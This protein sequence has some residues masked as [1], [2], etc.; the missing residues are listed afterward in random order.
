[1]N[2]QR[3]FLKIKFIILM[4]YHTLICS[5][6]AIS[7][8]SVADLRGDSS[9]TPIGLYAPALSKDIGIQ[10][11]QV[12]FGEKLIINSED[13]SGDSVHV[14]ALEQEIRMDGQKWIGCP[15][16]VHKN[17]IVETEVFPEYN[18]VL[19]DLWTDVY[20]EKNENSGIVITLACGTMLE[21]KKINQEWWQVYFLGK[22]FGFL[23]NSNSIYELT[24]D[25]K[26]SE[27][28]IRTRIVEI[29]KNFVSCPYVWGGR[30]PL[31]KKLENEI[32]GQNQIT[33]IDCSDFTNVVFKAVGLQIPKNSISQFLGVFKVIEHGKDLKPGDLL[34]FRRINDSKI[35]HVMLYIGNDETIESTGLGVSSVQEAID[36][37]ID[38]KNLG[39]RIIKLHDYIGVSHDQIES[40]KT[41][42]EKRGY[43]VCMGAYLTSR[44]DIL[45][46]RTK[47]F[48][49]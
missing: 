48:D 36:K 2:N 42:F 30:S 31:N 5:N 39:V 37:G 35:V 49:I 22:S 16:Y 47:L 17:Q 34:F 21:A 12:L 15:G 41:I 11:S 27:E 24:K 43:L 46:L 18:I 4:T 25:I 14:S 1:M 33:G 23:K 6:K 26:E 19:Q 29:A 40:D 9:E 3:K 44:E 32:T 8:V 13:K 10:L 28:E 20:R 38:P 45:K 7:V